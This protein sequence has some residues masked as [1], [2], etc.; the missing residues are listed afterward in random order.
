MVLD[1]KLEK[2]IQ[3]DKQIYTNLENS[4]V[5]YLS[6]KE[7]NPFKSDLF[8][9]MIIQTSVSKDT[10]YSFFNGFLKDLAVL[11]CKNYYLLIYNNKEKVEIKNIV[12]LINEDFG[13]KVNV[14]EGFVIDKKEKLIKFIN[15]YDMYKIDI[16]YAN[17]G[18]LIIIAKDN[19]ILKV[20][21]EIVLEKYICDKEFLNLVNS[22]FKNN[23][24]VSKTAADVYMHRNTIN[25][26]LSVFEK[27]TALAIQN[28]KDAVALYELLK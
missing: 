5:N 24:N 15:I 7:K 3:F 1:M 27:E 28:F 17:I 9:F 18:D 22:L 4:F 21:K 8:K 20:I 10:I 23:L 19:D 14:F 25:N 2:N 26:K 16:N 13:Q 11:K 6:D 12:D